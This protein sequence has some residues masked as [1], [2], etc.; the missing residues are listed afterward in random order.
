MKRNITIYQHEAEHSYVQEAIVASVWTLL[1]VVM[2][3]ASLLGGPIK[4]IETAHITTAR[5]GF[6]SQ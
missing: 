4:P 2:V 6:S 1:F 5:S 3:A